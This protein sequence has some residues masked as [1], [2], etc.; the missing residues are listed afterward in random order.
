MVGSLIRLDYYVVH[1][2][3]RI[4]D[5][6]FR[7]GDS[8]RIHEALIASYVVSRYDFLIYSPYPKTLR[9]IPRLILFVE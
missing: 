3:V 2:I 7:Y 6:I 1:S 4:S 9:I 5:F 8:T